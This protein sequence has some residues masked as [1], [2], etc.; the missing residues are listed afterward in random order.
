MQDSEHL[1]SLLLSKEQVKINIQSIQ[2]MIETKVNQNVPHGVANHLIELQ[3]FL[4]LS[5]VTQASARYYLEKKKTECFNLCMNEISVL[6]VNLAK[7]LIT[8]F[9]A[10]EISSYEMAERQNSCLV[11]Q[12]DATRSVLSFI[13]SELQNL[14]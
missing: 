13:K 8:S 6:K 7:D 12:I 4:S 11:H 2:K 3:S 1:E 9:C 5:V 14:K 10:T